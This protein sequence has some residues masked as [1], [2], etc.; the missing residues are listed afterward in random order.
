MVSKV[1]PT[2]SEIVDIQNAVYD[3]I[4]AF[5]LSPETALGSKYEQA[6]DTM[7]HLCYE[8]E[9]YINYTQRYQEQDKLLKMQLQA[10]IEANSSLKLADIWSPEEAIASCAVK[11]SFDVK[12]SLIIVFTNSGLTARKIAKHKPKCPVIAVS[13]N[14]WAAK[15]VLLHRGVE[16]MVVGSLIGSE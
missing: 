2:R 3:G 5:I 11:A 12:A 14:E 15:S 6:V 1:S 13:P 10:N 7:S 8:A 4:D 9:R 16:S